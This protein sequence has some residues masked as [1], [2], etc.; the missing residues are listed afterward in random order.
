MTKQTVVPSYFLY[1]LSGAAVL[2]GLTI[3]SIHSAVLTHILVEI[4]SIIIA[5]SIFLVAWNTRRFITNNYILF[6]G[7]CF[8]FV[9]FF[10]LLHTLAYKGMSVFPG[11]DPNLSAQLWITARYTGSISLLIAPVVM[12]WKPRPLLLFW[13][14]TV[15][16]A[17]L[18]ATIFIWR[19][20]PVCYI[21]GLGLTNFNIGS[22]YAIIALFTAALALLIWR[23][24]DFDGSIFLLLSGSILLR[25]ASEIT[26]IPYIAE[27]DEP[28]IVGNFFRIAAYYLFY[29]ALVESALVRPY[30]L[31][32]RNL[33]IREVSLREERDRAQHYLDVAKTL[34]VI[35]NAD[36]RVSLIN[37]KGCDILGYP[38]NEIIGKNWFDFFVP[39]RMRDE[40]KAVFNKLMAGE[41]QPVE[42]FENP[43]ISR[44]GEERLIAWHNA[45]LESDEGQIIATLSSGEDVTERKQAEEQLIQ[46][47]AEL[48]R[49]NAELEQFAAIV[50]H[51]LKEPLVSMG[52]FAQ[53]LR[54]KYKDNLDDKAQVLLSHIINGS[55]RMERLIRD[56]L[57]YAKV[58]ASEK[59]F[60]P[61]SCNA[62]L[63]VVLSNLGRAIEES[64]AVI[65]VDDLPTVT[66]EEMQLIQLFQ[67]LISNAIKYRSDQT[68]H[69]HVS[70]RSLRIDG[71]KAGDSIPLSTPHDSDIGAGWLFS[72]SDNG[73]GIDPAHSERIFQIFYRLHNNR[74]PG[75]GIGLAVCKKIVERHGGRIWVESEPG[76]GSTFYFT[77]P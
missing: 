33:K 22:E 40:V 4:F 55:F 49:S 37:R 43:V 70:A 68:P 30:D 1:L 6:I 66:G 5:C 73:I 27:S 46:K 15:A 10:D 35:I 38:E 71:M 60:I 18:L 51:D 48:E 20:F 42:H 61:L 3:I 75:S 74:Y 57:A 11:F 65:T 32:F 21:E 7:I 8:L 77:V 24:T 36:Q 2:I 50:S 62:I 76:K 64:G 53:I 41:I 47:T 63:G 19:I 29:K 52:G 45:V 59:S 34:L 28:N 14:A 58:N 12:D 44:Q 13:L 16:T 67:N 39:A 31:L 72:V 69:V 56:L 26:F 17:L 9:S 23:R 54:E 25:V